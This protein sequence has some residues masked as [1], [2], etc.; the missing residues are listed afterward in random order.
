MYC[1]KCGT[2]FTGDS[3]PKCGNP[4]NMGQPTIIINNTNSMTADATK[5]KRNKVTALLLCIFLGL[6]GAHK[7]YE[8]KAGMGVLYLFTAGL[9]GIGWIAD[10][11]TLAGK[12]NPYYV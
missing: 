7:F 1:Q 3:C 12:P 9:L 2:E 8:G 6:F 11:I 10:I 5:T 4:A